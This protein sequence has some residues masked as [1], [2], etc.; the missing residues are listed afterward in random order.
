MTT[1]AE[2]HKWVEEYNWDD[3]V[4]AI[5]RVIETGEIEFATALLIYW[6]LD[7][8]YLDTV[9]GAVNAEARTLSQSVRDGLLQGVFPK[10]G[11]RYDP[12]LD[13][14]LT[15]TQIY[16]LRRAGVPAELMEP[17]YPHESNMV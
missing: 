9:G 4:A 2:L 12:V 14:G 3:G 8:P 11:L 17:E 13:N 10:G 6:R 15:K 5:R 7:G 16:K 1:A